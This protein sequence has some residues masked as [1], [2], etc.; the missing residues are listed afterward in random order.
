MTKT[1]ALVKCLNCGYQFFT[2]ISRDEKIV[3]CPNCLSSDLI[4]QHEID[5]VV[6][7]T[8]ELI[9]TTV[10]GAF[11]SWDAVRSMVAERVWV[12]KR[13]RFTSMLN[14]LWIVLEELEKRGVVE[15]R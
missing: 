5:A 2:G 11:P 15:R 4:S 1:R 6:D 13:Y 12:S 9:E 10:F 8:I 14:L 3:H 7:Y